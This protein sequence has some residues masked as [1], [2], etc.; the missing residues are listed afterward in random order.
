MPFSLSSR[1]NLSRCYA[2]ATGT[3]RSNDMRATAA[4]TEDDDDD[5]AEDAAGLCPELQQRWRGAM[6]DRHAEIAAAQM[7]AEFLQQQQQEEE[8]QEEPHAVDESSVGDD[9]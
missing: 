1:T 9:Y 7:P 4:G 2:M 5:D 6:V 8:E 3:C